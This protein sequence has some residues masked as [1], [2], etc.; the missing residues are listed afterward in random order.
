M[1]A[2]G[3]I[4]KFLQQCIST[5]IYRFTTALA[6]HDIG[7]AGEQLTDPRATASLTIRRDA[8]R[9][10]AFYDLGPASR[11]RRQGRHRQVPR[12]I[13]LFMHISIA[14]SSLLGP[15]EQMPIIVE[16]QRVQTVAERRAMDAKG[17]IVKFIR[18]V[19][20]AFIYQ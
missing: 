20:P 1:D 9:R 15:P 7:H 19:I 14:S 16:P 2:K 17:V 13:Y 12:K 3:V 4:V 8:R 11:D 6:H 18:Q 10:A 5:R